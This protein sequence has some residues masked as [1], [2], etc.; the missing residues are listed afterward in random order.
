MHPFG[1]ST[2]SM[3]AN[4][5]ASG[6]WVVPLFVDYGEE[7]SLV[8]FASPTRITDAE[9]A[10]HLGELIAAMGNRQRGMARLTHP[11][12]DRFA[13]RIFYEPS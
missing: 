9:G 11:G 3:L 13:A 1:R 2:R 12:I 8:E 5:C 7:L 6:A 10:H 4:A